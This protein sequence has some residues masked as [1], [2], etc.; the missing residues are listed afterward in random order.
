ML[1][2]EMGG[3]RVDEWVVWMDGMLVGE[4]DAERVVV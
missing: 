3:W 1:A 2:D 4:M